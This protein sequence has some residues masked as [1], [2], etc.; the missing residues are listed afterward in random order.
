[1]LNAKGVAYRSWLLMRCRQV[2]P[3]ADELICDDKLLSM[4]SFWQ[5]HSELSLAELVFPMRWEGK[6][7]GSVS[8]ASV[9]DFLIRNKVTIPEII[10]EGSQQEDEPTPW[11]D[12]PIISDDP[13]TVGCLQADSCTVV[14]EGTGDSPIRFQPKC[15]ATVSQFLHAHAKLVESLDVEAITLNGFPISL[16]HVMEVGQ[17]IVIRTRKPQVLPEAMMS[18]DVV[19]PTV[20]WS[21]PVQDPIEAPSPPRKVLKISKFDVGDCGVPPSGLLPDQPWLDATPFLQL[22]GEQFLKLSPPMLTNTQQL[23]SVRHQFFRSNDRLCILEAQQQF[24]A[25]DEIRFHMNALIAAFRDYQ[26]RGNT[27]EVVELIS[28]NLGFENFAVHRVPDSLTLHTNMRAA[29]VAQLYAIENT[30]RP[31]VWGTGKQGTGAF[32]PLSPAPAQQQHLAKAS[33]LHPPRRGRQP[34]PPGRVSDRQV[35]HVSQA[36]NVSGGTGPEAEGSQ[37]VGRQ[38]DRPECQKQDAPKVSN[39]ALSHPSVRKCSSSSDVCPG[40]SMFVSQQSSSSRSCVE[41]GLHPGESGPLPIMPVSHAEPVGCLVARPSEALVSHTCVEAPTGSRTQLPMMPSHVCYAHD[42]LA[43]SSREDSAQPADS[44]TSR[45]SGPLPITPD[46]NERQIDEHQNGDEASVEEVAQRQARLLQVT[47]HSYAIADDEM[48][49]QLQHLMQCYVHTDKRCFMFAPPLAVFQWMLGDPND[50]DGWIQD[51]WSVRDADH[52]HLLVALLIESHWIPIWF[53]PSPEGLQAHT[54]AAFA[55]DEPL[56]DS[57]LHLFAARLGTKLHM[58]HRVPHG[59]DI[60]RLCGVMNAPTICSCDVAVGMSHLDTIIADFMRSPHRVLCCALLRDCHWTPV[61]AFKVGPIVY[62]FLE[63]DNASCQFPGCFTSFIPANDLQFCGAVTWVVLARVWKFGEVL[64]EIADIRSML[65]QQ[66]MGQFLPTTRIGFGPNGQRGITPC[67]VI[68]KTK[69]LI[70]WGKF[71]LFEVSMPEVQYRVEM[72]F[73]PLRE[74][75][76]ADVRKSILELPE[77]LTCAGWS[78][79]PTTLQE[80]NCY[81]ANLPAPPLPRHLPGL[82]QSAYRAEIFAVLRALQ[83]AQQHDGRVSAHQPD[84]AGDVYKEWCFRHNGIADRHAVR[85]NLT[86]DTDFWTLWRRHCTACEGIAWFNTHVHDVQL[87]ISR[88]ATRNGS[89]AIPQPLHE[90][91]CARP[92]PSWVSL[93]PLQVP[94]AAVRWYGDSLV[95]HIVSWFW[96]T[97][98]SGVHEMVWVS[99]FQLYVDFMLLTGLP[100]PVKQER[101]CDG[102][103]LTPLCLGNYAFRTRA[104]WFTKV[105]KEIL[106]HMRVTLHSDYGRPASQM[107]LMHAGIIAVPWP[108]ERLQMVDEWMLSHGGVTFRRQTVAIDSLPT[109]ERSSLFPPHLVSTF[110]L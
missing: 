4:I 47:S 98:F 107:V 68:L 90:P 12:C 82:L 46:G 27:P 52:S 28:H 76:P 56:V 35:A 38:L 5:D 75:V 48:H 15:C 8:I 44:S 7:A 39:L 30:P 43:R 32:R 92:C 11:M 55:S 31:V 85:A 26:L 63:P 22:Q 84:D 104:R 2:W 86:R 109:A 40:Q 36:V 108:P 66:A 70:R 74:H 96:A 37:A 58:I 54:L 69:L 65:Q 101:W 102:Q 41:A 42:D 60:D 50:L 89:P 10:S 72:Q 95:R 33:D 18:G 106:R 103:T 87:A 81:F 94:A 19:T 62:V 91:A 105:L 14:I 59:I 67:G 3:S 24:W 53:S 88:E 45:E 34:L 64:G 57:V 6:I 23:W 51:S 71:S 78:L 80:W 97:T 100:G 25:D 13:T 99:H 29:F 17:V 21:Q 93:P 20:E 77:V 83:I 49:F 61:L 16:E 9:L 110:G 1:M 73:E 79:Q